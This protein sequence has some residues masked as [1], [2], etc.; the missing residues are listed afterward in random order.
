MPQCTPSTIRKKERKEGSKERKKERVSNLSQGNPHK[1]IRVFIRK[2]ACQEKNA[3]TKYL[4]CFIEEIIQMNTTTSQKPFHTPKGNQYHMWICTL[5]LKSQ[6]IREISVINTY[7]C[8]TRA[9]I[10]KNG[11]TEGS[12]RQ[13]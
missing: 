8:N 13:Q 9:H 12:N 10:A 1:S 3:M 7:A 2:L 6:S 4:F 5:K 11:H